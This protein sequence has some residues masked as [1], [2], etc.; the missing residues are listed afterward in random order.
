MTKLID[1]FRHLNEIN[2]GTGPYQW[3][4]YAGIILVLIFEKKKIA[5]IIFAWLP[6]VF[7]ITIF[8]P[9][10]NKM[11]RIVFPIP[12]PYYV[13]LFSFIPVT[14]GIGIGM[15]QILIKMRGWLKTVCLAG[16]SIVIAVTCSNVYQALDM[17]PAV[18]PEKVPAGVMEIIA[19]IRKDNRKDISVA[20]PDPLNV[21]IRQVDAGLITPYGRDD[22]LSDKLLHELSQAVPDVRFVMAEAGKKSVDYIV[23]HRNDECRKAFR[24]QEYEPWAETTDYLIYAVANVPIIKRELNDLHQIVS[25]TN[26]DENGNPQKNTQGYT[27]TTYE[28]DSWG[29]TTQVKYLDENKNPYLLSD[30]YCAIKYSYRFPSGLLETL[31]FFNQED[32]PIM[33]NGC[34]ETRYRYDLNKNLEK[35]SYFDFDGH[36]MNRTDVFYAS[37]EMEY[38]KNGKI[39]REKYYD[40]NG[41]PVLSAAGFAMYTREYD[42]KNQLVAERYFDVDGQAM[43]LSDGCAGFT[44]AYD[45]KGNLISISYLDENGNRTARNNGYA[46]VRREYDKSKRLTAESF[47]DKEGN[48]CVLAAGYHA[49]TREYN[50]AGNIIAE[51]YLNEKREQTP[52]KTGYSRIE[53]KWNDAK[54]MT[55]E[56]YLIFNEPFQFPDGLSIIRREYDENGNILADSYYD[57]EENLI[58]RTIGYS[59]FHR[60]YDDFN[61]LIKES[62]FDENGNPTCNTSGYAAF[63]RDL[64]SHGWILRESYLDEQ[65]DPASLSVGYSSVIREYNPYGSV[66]REIYLDKDNNPVQRD[67]GY[68]E[69]RRDYDKYKR[70]VS[71]SYWDEKEEPAEFDGY[72]RIERE[73]DNQGNV[74]EERTY[75]VSG[76]LVSRSEGYA[77]V[78]R[79]WN[80]RRQLLTEAYF[81]V[82]NEP[83]NNTSGVAQIKR[84][85]SGWEMTDEKKTDAEGNAL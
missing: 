70:L 15:M 1:Y 33:M 27:T 71:E 73:Y 34:F 17:K 40:A 72:H 14:Y 44:R 84:C 76:N 36:P 26:L 47:W 80:D 5:R 37:K 46:E 75:D 35:E 57:A 64:D 53:R 29:Y 32:K 28:Y 20:V 19:T 68:A 7:L 2:W 77:I 10:F 62:Y 38:N 11:I 74:V 60:E 21:S 4:F 48:P 13:R 63:T 52:L 85:Y 12:D 66:I 69:F 41:K 8:N 49:Y 6:L 3:L 82:D 83:V 30:G 67:T 16:L 43:K 39:T 56:R 65:G 78:R 23:V 79:T 31:G 42:D 45:E 25:E 24:E 61:R 50:D 58:R 54:K 22:I 59:S 51:T 55:E 18:N 9:F 81:G